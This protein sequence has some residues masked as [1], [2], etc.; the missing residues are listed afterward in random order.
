MPQDLL[1]TIYGHLGIDTE[2]GSN[3]STGRP[4]PILQHGKPIQQLI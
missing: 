4:M 3:D 2:H 1:A